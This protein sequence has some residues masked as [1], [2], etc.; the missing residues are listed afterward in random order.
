MRFDAIHPGPA[1]KPDDLDAY[2]GA[3]K[4]ALPDSLR[5][6]LLDQNG[7]APSADIFVPLPDGDETDLFCLFGLMMRDASSELARVVEI[8]AGRVPV[9][10]VPFANDSGGNLFLVGS[11]DLVS[12][13]DHEQEGSPAAAVPMNVSLDRF[14]AV[15][16]G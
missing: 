14:L 11:D 9:G 13:W 16:A 3:H 2:C 7:G 1:L 6:Q 8:Y 4:L 10:L 5:R 15:L 12:F